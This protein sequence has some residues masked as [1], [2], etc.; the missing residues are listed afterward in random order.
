MAQSVIN[1]YN[2]SVTVG[3][4]VAIHRP[5]GGLDTGYVVKIAK[6]NGAYRVTLNSGMT[7]SPDDVAGQVVKS[8][9]QTVAK[10]FI[11]AAIWADK[12]EELSEYDTRATRASE[13][14]AEL[15]CADFIAKHLAL[16]LRAMKAKDNGYG[17]HPDAGSP[18]AAFGH[19]L[20]L[21]MQGHGVGFWDRKELD[22]DEGLGD[23]LSDAC[24]A[25]GEPSY[26]FG[27]RFFHL[28][29]LR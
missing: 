8:R 11:I 1:R 25:Y 10:H 27:T 14:N 12:P 17:S 24:R 9:I 3:D 26:D 22:E 4:V 21:T 2:K 28:E 7:C 20:W 23:A 19:D 16:F 5:R 13:K 6:E 18:E 29:A 15:I